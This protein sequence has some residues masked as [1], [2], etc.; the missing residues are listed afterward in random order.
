MGISQSTKKLKTEESGLLSEFSESIWKVQ[1]KIDVPFGMAI[2]EDAS[3]R[4]YFTVNDNRE[5]VKCVQL[6]ILEG[7][8]ISVPFDLEKAL[9]EN[10]K[11]TYPFPNFYKFKGKKFIIDPNSSAGET[12]ESFE[13]ALKSYNEYIE[14]S[15]YIN[16][17]DDHTIVQNCI[18]HLRPKIKEFPD[19][20][21]YIE[22]DKFIGSPIVLPEGPPFNF[23]D[24]I[25][26]LNKSYYELNLLTDDRELEGLYKIFYRNVRL[27]EKFI[28]VNIELPTPDTYNLTKNVREIL[29]KNKDIFTL[30]N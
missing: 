6:E 13:Q 5:I 16:L 8:V 30:K 29:Q 23:H 1:V 4:R 11:F 22:F 24:I 26:F 27:Y 20:K 3:T 28:K 17:L 10:K 14:Y 15:G 9:K 21:K 2:L 19:W 7:D 12:L 18:D 25:L